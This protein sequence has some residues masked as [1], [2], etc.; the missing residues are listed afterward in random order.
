ME[1]GQRSGVREWGIKGGKVYIMA[2]ESYRQL[3]VWQMGMELAKDVYLLTK[4]FPK[5]EVHGLCSQVQRSVVSIPANLAEGHAKES[6]KEFLRHISIAQGSLAETKTHLLLAESLG[7][8]KQQDVVQLLD[9]CTEER[10]MLSGL[11]RSL[12]NNLNI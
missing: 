10:K 6:T 12:Q 9:K 5:H 8:G 4:K 7:Y 1:R 11:R 3:K 2:L